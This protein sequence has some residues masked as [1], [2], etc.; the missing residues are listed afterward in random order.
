MV[1]IKVIIH[2]LMSVHLSPVGAT[3]NRSGLVPCPQEVSGS[4][5]RAGLRGTDPGWF[6]Q[7]IPRQLSALEPVEPNCMEQFN[8]PD[9]KPLKSNGR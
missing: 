3:E 9:T 1:L 5:L 2:N 6:Q 4:L 7:P 8:C